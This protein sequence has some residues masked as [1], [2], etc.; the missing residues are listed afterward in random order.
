MEKKTLKSKENA[1]KC[2]F[3]FKELDVFYIPLQCYYHDKYNITKFY[4]QE[5]RRWSPRSKE[6]EK[7]V[8]LVIIYMN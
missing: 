4:L 6:K 2:K 1:S 7:K 5:K 3:F 8:K